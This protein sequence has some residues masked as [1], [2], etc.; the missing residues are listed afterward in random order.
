MENKLLPN[1]IYPWMQRRVDLEFASTETEVNKLRVDLARALS[2]L[3]RLEIVK[4]CQHNVTAVGSG[5]PL[6]VAQCTHCGQEWYY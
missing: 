6:D 3:N 2:N 1:G 4:N 5:G